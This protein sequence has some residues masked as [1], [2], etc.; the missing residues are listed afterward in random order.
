[1]ALSVLPNETHSNTGN[2]AAEAQA[3]QI[4]EEL[5]PLVT[6]L[7]ALYQEV[8]DKIETQVAEASQINA[9]LSDAVGLGVGGETLLKWDPELALSPKA[10]YKS[11]TEVLAKKAAPLFFSNRVQ[12]SSY[13]YQ[14]LVDWAMP[15]SRARMS[16]QELQTAR[17]HYARTRTVSAFFNELTIRFA[18]QSC[19]DQAADRATSELA[20]I[21]SVS[22]PI[23]TVIPVLRGEA[24]AI[25]VYQMYHR[26]DEMIWHLAQRHYTAI[27]KAANSIATICLLNEH[28]GAA[29]AIGEMLNQLDAK[30]AKAH[31]QYEDGDG[32]FA[33]NVLRVVMH[34]DTA[35]FQVGETVHALLDKSLREHVSDVR[36]IH[37]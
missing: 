32:L 23:G 8:L 15:Y 19:P 30:M 12:R 9:E 26:D 17:M 33:G 7:D 1:M 24:P 18:P 16:Q 25:F 4:A 20:R 34:R 28:G 21:F 35:D 27:V 22:T 36:L 14:D 29:V 10:A 13:R 3:R 31:G 37:Q 5:A 11:F 2:S 6:K